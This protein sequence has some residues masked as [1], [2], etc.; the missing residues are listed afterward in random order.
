M[1]REIDFVDQA[2]RVK[3]TQR[4]RENGG[5]RVGGETKRK[6]RRSLREEVHAKAVALLEEPQT[7]SGFWGCVSE[8]VSNPP[9]PRRTKLVHLPVVHTSPF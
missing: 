7:S 5:Q 4:R 1:L 6:P 2:V 3:M 8:G 9:L